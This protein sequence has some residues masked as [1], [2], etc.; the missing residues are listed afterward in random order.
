[1]SE[2]MIMLSLPPP[3]RC[4]VAVMTLE[5]WCLCFFFSFWP[6]GRPKNDQ[7]GSQMGQLG[8]LGRLPGVI[9]ATWS[10]LVGCQVPSEWWKLALVVARWPPGGRASAKPGERQAGAG[11]LRY[12]FAKRLAQLYQARPSRPNLQ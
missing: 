9:G 8:P 1:M 12:A 10:G 3:I 6:P 5:T 11:C 2:K 7:V 4:D